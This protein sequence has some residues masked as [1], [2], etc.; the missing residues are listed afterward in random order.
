[1]PINRDRKAS[2]TQLAQMQTTRSPLE[3]QND[4]IGGGIIRMATTA[5]I[6]T[7]T[8]KGS[9]AEGKTLKI[10]TVFIIAYIF[11]SGLIFIR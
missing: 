3:A 9:T 1:M 7:S 8:A 11:F 2:S 10:H 4:A 5:Q 6:Q